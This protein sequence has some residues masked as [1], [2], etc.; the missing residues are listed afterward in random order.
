MLIGD[1]SSLPWLCQVAAEGGLRVAG[2]L[3]V[4]EFRPSSIGAPARRLG[5][6]EDVESLVTGRI[7]DAALVSLPLQRADTLNALTAK[8]DAT[9]L[10]WSYV[11]TLTDTLAGRVRPFEP[12]LA[13]PTCASP[14]GTLPRRL[15]PLHEIDPAVLID[16]TPRPLDDAAIRHCNAGRTVLIT[17][18][19]GSIGSE[20]A[21]T[22]AR[23]S[24]ARLVL[25]ERSENPLFE[26]DR[27]IARMFPSLER[28]AE[29]HDV[30]VAAG[31]MDLFRVYRPDVVIHA[32][33]HKHVPMMESH[34]AAAVE[35]NFYGT[36]AVVDASHRFAV[37]RC[38]MISTDKAVNPSSIMG[39]TKRL[40]ELYVQG[41]AAR[42]ATAWRGTGMP[43]V[44]ATRFSVV[45]FGNV[46]GSACS[47]LPI[48]TD[49]LSRGLPL[50]VT[51]P[52]MTRYFMTIP[53]AAGLVLQAA[54]MSGAGRTACG[55]VFLLDMGHPVRILDLARRFIESHGLI[56]DVDVPIRTTGVRPGEKLHE[57]L[58]Y[59]AESMTPTDHPSIRRWQTAPP[60]R[61]HLA[62]ITGSFDRLRDRGGDPAHPWRGVPP[63]A[64]AAALRAAVPEMVAA[65][66]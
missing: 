5:T 52:E 47:V 37:G 14:E 53:E 57:T 43:P 12:V 66:A 49:Q 22:V 26:I 33:A 46:L 10:R 50:T 29:L 6:L 19:G 64:V 38:V 61:A 31:T 48:W 20:L 45:R 2:Y 44:G 23:F 58:A 21:R 17:G 24:P 36:R 30:T 51:H 35:N 3:C 54:A 4:D 16:R 55:E 28:F 59:D 1:A 11:P 18:A 7:V 65:A 56:P 40:A 32:A 60:S 9:A 63:E 41:A 39:A 15:R 42:G 8:L 13:R 62:R 25:V 34:P 27:S